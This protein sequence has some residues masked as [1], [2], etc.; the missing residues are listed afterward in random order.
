MVVDARFQHSTFQTLRDTRP[1]GRRVKDGLEEPSTGITIFTLLAVGVMVFPPATSAA[2]FILLA[3]LLYF[4]WYVKRPIKLPMKM[5][6]FSSHKDPNERDEKP[7]GILYLGTQKKTNNELWLSNTDAKTHI[8]YLGTT[9][10]GKTVGLTSLAANA[11]TWGSGFIF[12]DGKA[13]TSLYASLYALARRFGR[14]DDLLV[15]NYLTANSD[16][17]SASNSINPF[18][19]GSSSYLTNLVVSLM[20]E[21]KGENAMWKGRAV[22]LMGAMMP[23]LTYKR[24]TQGT[25][26]DVTTIQESLSLQAVIRLSRDTSLP[27]RITAGLKNYLETLP[28][29]TAN[30]FDDDGNEAPPGPNDPPRDT[31]VPFQ[32]HGFLAMQ[33]TRA[34]QSL[35]G[36]YGYI[37]GSQLADIIMQDV[38]LNRR[39]LIVLIP[40]LEKSADEAANLGKIIASMIKGMMGS[41]LGN[42][43][44]GDWEGAIDNK[45]TNS[46]SPFLTIFD[47]VGYYTAQGMAVMAAQARSLG[48]ALVFASQDIPSMELRVKEEARSITANCNL[49]IFGKLEESIDTRN[50][51]EKSVGTDT[52]SEISGFQTNPGGL[53][54]GYHEQ[55]QAVQKSWAKAEWSDLR[56]QKEGEVHMTYRS[57]VIAAQMFYAAPKPVKAMRVHKMLGVEPPSPVPQAEARALEALVANLQDPKW[58]AA[59]VQ[60]ETEDSETLDALF[61]GFQLAGKAKLEARQRGA[62][63]VAAVAA[64]M[65]KEEPQDDD[66][67]AEFE[68]FLA[69]DRDR[70]PALTADEPLGL[71]VPDHDEDD[72]FADLL[73]PRGAKAPADDEAEIDDRHYH[74]ALSAEV[75]AM[76]VGAATQLT[77]GLDGGVAGS[78]E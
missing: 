74:P 7:Q 48:F 57:D 26:L 52:V 18:S 44:E 32:Q 12:I 1:F 24:D 21:A 45:P 65:P 50:F 27:D 60:V 75:N 47:E 19:S 43:I 16:A 6:L 51:F 56:S 36:D 61:Y 58:T 77:L 63:A 31:T 46:A 73:K 41:T 69:L 29:F 22:A 35:S 3:G 10:A 49:K 68:D 42:T 59:G 66:L 55:N 64:Y 33:F 14:D 13:D 67:D 17:G 11:L 28:G 78:A 9:G 40:S 34:L 30:A 38:V 15:L 20:D 39:I 54:G 2:D 37:F 76:L 71:P 53:I 8:L 4:W 25:R 62:M 23:V 70:K 72:I 5:P